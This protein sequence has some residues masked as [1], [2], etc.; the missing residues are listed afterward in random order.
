[1][2]SLLAIAAHP[3]DIEFVMSGTMLHLAAVGWELHYFNLANGCCGSNKLG[4][5]QCAAVRLREAQ[6]SAAAL[7]AVFH[8]PM[9]NDLEIFYTPELH[10]RVAAVIRQV[11]PSIVLTHAPIDYMEDRQ[12]ASRL[13]ISAAFVRAM[14]N[15]ESQPPLPVYDAPVAIYHAQPHGNR[16]P[17]GNL[18][19]PAYFV[20][21]TRHREKKRQLLGL[22]TS[23]GD[24]LDDTQAL[25]SYLD[26]MEEL[27]RE[28]GQM[29]GCFELAEGWRRHHHLG[30]SPAD[31]DPLLTAL[32]SQTVQFCKPEQP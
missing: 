14:P 26:T 28:V 8:P 29:S 31:F 20:D 16:D 30:F 32:P 17:L 12:N 27:N 2:P 21:V 11:R 18:V 9:C 6:A 15:F 1:M 5:E 25:A 24:W 3:D 22:H 4:R 7:P 19:K 23:Q 10:A 13:A